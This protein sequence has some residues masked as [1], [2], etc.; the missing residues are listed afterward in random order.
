MGRQPSVSGIFNHIYMRKM[1]SAISQTTAPPPSISPQPA[2]HGM[3]PARPRARCPHRITMAS[4]Q[5]PIQSGPQQCTRP[6]TFLIKYSN[7]SSIKKKE[8]YFPHSSIMER[9][10]GQEEFEIA[11]H[12]TSKIKKQKDNECSMSSLSLCLQ[13]GNPARS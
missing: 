5:S 13:S 8:S 12:I 11:G 6:S 2:L 1:S 9:K 7:R 3:I 10:L 4:G